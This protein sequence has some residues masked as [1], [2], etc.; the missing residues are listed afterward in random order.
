[1][2]RSS[3]AS[4]FLDGVTPYD[5]WFRESILAATLEALGRKAPVLR[6]HHEPFDSASATLRAGDSSDRHIAENPLVTILIPTY[7]RPALLPEALESIAR[8]TYAPVEAIVI[9][10][11]GEPVGAIVERFGATLV[12]M[13]QNRGH[14][15]ALNAGLARARGSYIAFLDDDDLV[16]PDHVETL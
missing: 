8:Q 10:D 13:P 1:V 11:G 4:E 3:G 15:A 5:P 2:A 6:C 7:N 9:N 16:F 14:A 12:E